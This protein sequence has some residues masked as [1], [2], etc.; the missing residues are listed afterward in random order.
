MLACDEESNLF[1]SQ[2][3]AAESG[4][5][6][7]FVLWRTF[8]ALG[9]NHTQLRRDRLLDEARATA[10]PVHLMRVFGITPDTAMNYIYAA[11]PDRRPTRL[12]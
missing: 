12:G 6:N 1:I 3:S 11:H 8:D 9:I 7:A 2:Q 10:D 5:V 4:P